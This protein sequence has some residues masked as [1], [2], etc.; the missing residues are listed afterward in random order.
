MEERKTRKEET[1][2]ARVPLDLPFIPR[3][4]ILVESRWRRA[5]SRQAG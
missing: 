4:G 2:E 1:T 5:M 3:S